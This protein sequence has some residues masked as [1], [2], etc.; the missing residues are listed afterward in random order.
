MCAA[1]IGPQGPA[2]RRII[3]NAMTHATSFLVGASIFAGALGGCANAPAESDGSVAETTD[4]LSASVCPPGVPATLLPAADQTIKLSL[5]GVGVQVYMC[6]ATA[7]GG[8]AWTFVSPQANLSTDDGKLVGTH[9]IGPSWQGNDGSSVLAAKAAA[10][11]VDATAIP[12]LLLNAVSH[13]SEDGRF[14]D[15]T[16][17]QRLNTVGGI[18]PADGCDSA[19]LGSI[20]Q[21]PYTA[22]YVF[23]KTKAQGKV[24]QCGPS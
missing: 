4:A 11:T 23:Y 21:V 17:V 1:N 7:A 22:Q 8:F 9:F 24:N 6:N 2:S 14:S 15:V 13:G 5:T 3:M 20:A 10:A 18:A 19:H 16:A 12:W